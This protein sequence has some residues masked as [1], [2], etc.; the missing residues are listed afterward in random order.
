M[1]KLLPLLDK[2]CHTGLELALGY[3][4]SFPELSVAICGAKN[5]NQLQTLLKG[6]RN[7]PSLEVLNESIELAKLAQK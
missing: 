6:P 4:L 2:N 5:S 3:N 7:L 1:K